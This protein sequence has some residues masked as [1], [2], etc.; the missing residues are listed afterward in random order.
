MGSYHFAVNHAGQFIDYGFSV[1]LG[2]PFA[3]DTH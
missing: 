3:A 1:M 2:S